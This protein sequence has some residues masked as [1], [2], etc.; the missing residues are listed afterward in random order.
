MPRFYPSEYRR[1]VIDLIESGMS[2]TEVAGGLEVTAAT[3]YNWWN[4]HLVDTGRKPG[5]SSVESTELAAANRRIV[6]LETELAAARRAN[7]LLRVV[8]PPKGGSKPSPDGRGGPSGDGFDPG[9]LRVGFGVLGVEEE[10]AVET[11]DSSHLADRPDR[12]DPFRL[13]GNL[14]GPAGPR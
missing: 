10:I 2:V 5:T 3:I 13:E 12:D 4:Q 7:E 9:V 8:V 11:G 6:E 14:R 1:R